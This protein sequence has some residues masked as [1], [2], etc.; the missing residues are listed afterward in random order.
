MKK[1]VFGM[2]LGLSTMMFT[3]CGGGDSN[4]SPSLP[5]IDNSELS[6]GQNQ[7]GYYGEKVIFGSSLMAGKWQLYAVVDGEDK[8]IDNNFYDDGFWTFG[9]YG[10]SKDGKMMHNSDE[11]SM[12]IT[13]SA[14]DSC[15]NVHISNPDIGSI[16]ATMCRI[17]DVY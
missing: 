3:A 15:Y 16:D 17:S 10:V 8:T 12:N 13:S 11:D 14:G 5:S 9:Q 2:L 1:I 4:T 6:D 7:Y